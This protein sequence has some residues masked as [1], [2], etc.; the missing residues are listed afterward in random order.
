MKYVLKMKLT[1]NNM[2]LFAI[3][4]MAVTLG[5]VACCSKPATN[6]GDDYPMPGMPERCMNHL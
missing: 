2:R 3:S 6:G 4:M 1:M 5:L